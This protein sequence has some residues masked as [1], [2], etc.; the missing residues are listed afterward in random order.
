MI[1]IVI[2]RTAAVAAFTI[3]G[4]LYVSGGDEQEVFMTHESVIKVENEASAASVPGEDAKREFFTT[5]ADNNDKATETLT[6][7]NLKINI[8]KA[9]EQELTTLCGIGPAK[10][11][12]IIA[13]R[14]EHGEFS[15][16]E[17][18]MLVPGIKEGT[19]GKIKDSITVR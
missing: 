11:R 16:I 4:I 8:N 6:S 19:F 12:K 9:D 3:A 17:D 13:F 15:D 14:T 7:V 1:M 18:L 5:T 10:A 2:K